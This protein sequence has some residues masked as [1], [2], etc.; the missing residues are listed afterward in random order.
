M[1]IERK[2]DTGINII[3][4]YIYGNTLG[5][6]RLEVEEKLKMQN[7]KPF[8]EIVKGYIFFNSNIHNEYTSFDELLEWNNKI[9]YSLDEISSYYD[10]VL[11]KYKYSIKDISKKIHELR[12][13]DIVSKI[14]PTDERNLMSKLRN[15]HGDCI[16]HNKGFLVDFFDDKIT[17]F[18][19]NCQQII[20]CGN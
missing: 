8:P 9:F 6:S 11:S 3:S 19:V 5:Y 1:K 4:I 2:F 18:C 10:D 14:S 20:S 15:T 16:K 17:L 7:K 13:L 12:D